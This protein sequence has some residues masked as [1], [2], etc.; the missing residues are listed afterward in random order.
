MLDGL[1]GRAILDG[2]RGRS[3]V[4]RRALAAAIVAVARLAVR[5]PEIDEL[6]LN[7]VFA[8]SD[9][10]VVVDWLMRVR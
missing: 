5:H 1:K 3:P 8:G 2:A 7:P 6:D 9:G 4:D 10:I